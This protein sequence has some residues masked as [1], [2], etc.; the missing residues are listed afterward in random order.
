MQN[1]SPVDSTFWM[2]EVP[3]SMMRV[4]SPVLRMR[5]HLR[6]R[7]IV[8]E[9]MSTLMDLHMPPSHPPLLHLCNAPSFPT[10]LLKMGRLYFTELQGVLRSLYE[11]V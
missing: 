3:R 10:L 5:C 1:V 2:A 4:T 9:N 11:V 7:S 6:S 8:L